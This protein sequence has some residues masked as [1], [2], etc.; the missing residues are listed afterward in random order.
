MAPPTHAEYIVKFSGI[1]SGGY[2]EQTIRTSKQSEEGSHA[3]SNEA[4][5]TRFEKKFINAQNK[6]TFWNKC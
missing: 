6:S 1:Y 4:T 2:N 5:I 3:R